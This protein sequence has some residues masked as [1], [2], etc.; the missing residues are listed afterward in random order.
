VVTAR[1][2]DAEEGHAVMLL[3][4]RA[5]Q[6]LASAATVASFEEYRARAP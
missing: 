6:D 2:P 4:E 1:E 5:L 3:R